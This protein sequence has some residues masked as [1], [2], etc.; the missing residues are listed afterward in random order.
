MFRCVICTCPFNPS[1]RNLILIRSRFWVMFTG[2]FCADLWCSVATSGNG[3]FFRTWISNF[4]A[5]SREVIV[6]SRGC[7]LQFS[8]GVIMLFSV[9]TTF[10]QVY[11]R[12]DV[13]HGAEFV[14]LSMR[15]MSDLAPSNWILR[16]C[17]HLRSRFNLQL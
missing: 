2:L 14:V 3:G 10:D 17:F 1:P 5:L 6:S 15:H 7:L 13:L 11:G 9:K 16:A 4:Q 12:I 8:N